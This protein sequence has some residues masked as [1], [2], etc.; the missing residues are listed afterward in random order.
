MKV[1]ITLSGLAILLCGIVLGQRPREKPKELDVLGQYVGDWTSEVT[2]KPAV[3]T[4]QEVQYRATNHAEFV[5]NGR[6]LQH[7]EVNHVVGDPNKITKS[8]FLCFS[9]PMILI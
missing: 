6:Y 7:I 1:P 2:S 5:L 9:G 4:P 3:W 8:L